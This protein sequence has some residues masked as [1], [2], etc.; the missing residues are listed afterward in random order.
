M[1][2][3]AC[4][5]AEAAGGTQAPQD[6]LLA[7]LLPALLPWLSTRRWFSHE[8][9]CIEHVHAVTAS[10]L[11]LTP[12]TDSA[13]LLH[14]VVEVEHADGV[15]N[16]Y[17]LLVGV[18]QSMPDALAG[19]GFGR[20]RGG[21]W[22]GWWLYEATEDPELT[23]LLMESAAAG[24][25]GPDLALVLTPGSAITA[26]L[27]PRLL[28]VEQ[29]NTAVVYGDALLLKLFRRPQ[30][31]RHPETEV[32]AALTAAGSTRT[33]HL[34]GW[35]ADRAE[36][37]TGDG[38]T[39]LGI[40]EEFLASQGDG[41]EIAVEYAKDCLSGRTPGAA[42]LSR[43]VGEARELGAAVAAVHRSLAAAFP[44]HR[45]S[46]DLVLGQVAEMQARLTAAIDLV[47][48]LEPY[49][50]RILLAYDQYASAALGGG[51]LDGQRT[52]GDLHLG[53]VLRTAD[54]WHVIDFEGEP[55]RP[56]HERA[57]PQSPL[58]DVAGML[59]SF[60]YAAQHALR[61][62]HAQQ[63]EPNTAT[64][65]R[66]ERCAHAW[67]IRNRHAFTEGYA[68]AGGPDPRYHPVLMRALELDKAV[69][70]AHYEASHRPDWLPVPMAA[71]HRVLARRRGLTVV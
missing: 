41:W 31:G 53:Q 17:Q 2:V 69:Y 58:R 27:A 61:E 47:P 55:N 32:L 12:A 40:V 64:G 24:R 56:V 59:R 71:I 25:T 11:R 35:L 52:H 65:L 36:D 43:F 57:L 10:R 34:V 63:P 3:A 60:D 20:A 66:Q 16:R 54:G 62:T 68:T 33:P 38:T 46:D 5:C 42:G 51:G 70:E 18:R 45:L 50:E 37:P 22:D 19:A 7:P 29:S 4:V 44:A 26:G 8:R 30:P 6:A 9:G 21:P 23:G 13:Q 39:V 15:A 1:T 14:L 48:D 67:A 49:A 28:A